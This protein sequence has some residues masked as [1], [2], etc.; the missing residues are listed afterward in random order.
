MMHWNDP[1]YAGTPQ[2]DIMDPDYQTYMYGGT[3][4]SSITNSDSD[5]QNHTSITDSDDQNHTSLTRLPSAG[6]L[7]TDGLL[8]G[9]F[10][11]RVAAAF[12]Y[13]VGLAD[14]IMEEIFTRHAFISGYMME[15][16]LDDAGR[17]PLFLAVLAVTLHLALPGAP[18][19]SRDWI[20]R[21]GLKI[22]LGYLIISS[23]IRW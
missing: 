15:W 18:R 11:V 20:R 23:A 3:P 19:G 1:N 2:S 22:C 4:P 12:H 14:K 10:G 17:D 6:R 5:D 21:H 8:R 7:V 13:G 9:R 16:F